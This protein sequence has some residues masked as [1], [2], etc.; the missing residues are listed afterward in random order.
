MTGTTR[1]AF[2]IASLQALLAASLL[3]QSARAN[4]LTGTLKW[5]VRPWL[6]RLDEV[7]AALSAGSIAP[8]AWQREIAR[9]WRAA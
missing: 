2:G 7:S 8:R 5:S 4:A 1:R 6:R 9:R 3:R